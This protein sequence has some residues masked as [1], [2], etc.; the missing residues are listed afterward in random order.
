M[1]RPEQ[2]FWMDSI[3]NRQISKFNQWKRKNCKLVIRSKRTGQNA[4]NVEQILNNRTANTKTATYPQSM[5]W[6]AFTKKG[7]GFLHSLV[8][9][10]LWLTGYMIVLAWKLS[11]WPWTSTKQNTFHT[12]V[13]PNLKTKQNSLLERVE[14]GK[15]LRMLKTSYAIIGTEQI[16]V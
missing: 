11:L 2:G 6:T 3:G 15:G 16:L 9:F 13:L 1:T 10:H 14:N 12:L 7:D 8:W 5:Y 4:L